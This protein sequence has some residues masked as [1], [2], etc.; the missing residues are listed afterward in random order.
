MSECIWSVDRWFCYQPL[1]LHLWHLSYIQRRN[2]HA[3]CFSLLPIPTPNFIINFHSH[4]I[5]IPIGKPIPMV[6]SNPHHLDILKY[7]PTYCATVQLFAQSK[8]CNLRFI[9]D[10]YLQKQK[11]PRRVASGR[12]TES[13][14]DLVADNNRCRNWLVV[15]ELAAKI[16]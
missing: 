13:L 14:H 12:R 7:C 5:P 9:G 3:G 15:K 4:G 6:F 10:I 8:Y 16:N 2:S 1:A 11:A